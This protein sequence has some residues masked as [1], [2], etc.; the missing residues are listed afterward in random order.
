MKGGYVNTCLLGRF[1]SYHNL[2]NHSVT[3]LEKIISTATL[4]HLT[5]TEQHW[6]REIFQRY[7]GRYPC[8][9]PD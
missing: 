8:T 4:A 1:A 2:K 5:P 6:L 9:G 7:G 3:D